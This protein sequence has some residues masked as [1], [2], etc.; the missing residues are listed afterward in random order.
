MGQKWSGRGPLELVA[1]RAGAA[2]RK[3]GRGPKVKGRGMGRVNSR[4][5]FLFSILFFRRSLVV[6]C[7]IFSQI[8]SSF[9]Y[10]KIIQR[11][12]CL[13]N[14]KVKKMLLKSVKSIESYS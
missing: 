1:H 5:S 10:S 4:Q 12:F 2:R 8:S 11:N 9:F 6:F 14:R 3:M 13:G 7:L